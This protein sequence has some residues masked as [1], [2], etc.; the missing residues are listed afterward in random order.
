MLARPP[1]GAIAAPNY[2]PNFTVQMTTP[3]GVFI[4]DRHDRYQ[5][6]AIL[7]TGLPHIVAEIE[8]LNSILDTLEPGAVIVDAGANIGLL[9]VPMG[10]KLEAR[11]GSVIAFEPQRLLFYMLAGNVVLNGLSNVFCHQLALS[12]NQE[13]LLSPQVDYHAPQDFGMVQLI[14]VGLSNPAADEE[15]VRAVSIDFMNLQRVDLIKIDVET[16]ELKVLRGAAATL[17]RLR[18]LVWIEVWREQRRDVRAFLL[19]RRYQL[20]IVDELN[21][22]CVPQETLE[23]GYSVTLPEF[24]GVNHPYNP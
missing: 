23:A 7:E 4:M 10:R 6:R 3:Y 1:P 18:P 12:D 11:G 21:F 17:E 9:A 16:M 2:V 15:E 20:F 13:V 19:E 8:A 22:F 24:D 5:P 14:D